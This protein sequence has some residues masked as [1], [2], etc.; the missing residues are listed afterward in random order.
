[1]YCPA[2]ILYATPSLPSQTLG[3]T[4]SAFTVLRHAATC[5][6]CGGPLTG[7]NSSG[8]VAQ[9]QCKCCYKVLI[10]FI[11]LQ[12]LQMSSNVS[13]GGC[14]SVCAH[15][16]IKSFLPPST[17]DISCVISFT[18]PSSRLFFSGKGSTAREDSLGTRLHSHR[19]AGLPGSKKSPD[20]SSQG[21]VQWRLTTKVY[22]FVFFLLPFKGELSKIFQSPRYLQGCMDVN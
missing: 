22:C 7:A 6:L 17:R 18:R 1:M 16:A 13:F 3:S 8:K 14:G 20:P 2:T 9:L 19:S 4:V 11:T 21:R 10:L 5:Y 15:A 12:Q